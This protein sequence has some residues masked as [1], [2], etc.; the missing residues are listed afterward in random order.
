MK[1]QASIFYHLRELRFNRKRKREKEVRKRLNIERA[2]RKKDVSQRQNSKQEYRT[3]RVKPEEA[4]LM[5]TQF[6]M[7]S[8]PVQ[9]LKDI[10]KISTITNKYGDNCRYKIDLSQITDIDIG[11][12]CLLLSKINELGSRNIYIW[13]NLPEN[14]DCSNFI[15]NSG[16]LDHMNDLQ[17]RRFPK[18]ENNKNLLIK[19]GFDRTG[20]S[21]VGKEIKKVVK[22]LTGEEESFRPVFSMVQEMCANSIEHAN[23]DTGRKNWLFAIYYEVDRVV[24]TMTDIGQGILSTLRKKANQILVDTLRRNDVDVLDRAFEK[25]YQS[26]TSDKNRNKG[27]PKIKKIND[28]HYV[29]NLIVITNNVLLNFNDEKKSEI[30]ETKFYGTF[31][32]WELTKNCIDR[33]KNRQLN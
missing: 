30:L 11:A 10:Q 21:I 29:D 19:R 4:I 9:V 6:S 33:W 31:Y 3:Q 8:T 1:A 18:N 2:K 26:A 24:F 5:G 27:L 12:V 32:Y 17:G 7:L 16:F 28:E 13:G 15:Y 20:N 23:K 25:K 22:H 14:E